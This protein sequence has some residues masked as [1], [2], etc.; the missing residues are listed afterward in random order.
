MMILFTF[1]T[2]NLCHHVSAITCVFL[3]IIVCVSYTLCDYF[4]LVVV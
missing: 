4:V 3:F 2:V 1:F